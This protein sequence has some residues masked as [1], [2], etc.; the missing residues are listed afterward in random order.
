[1]AYQIVAID[2]DLTNKRKNE[3]YKHDDEDEAFDENGL[4]RDGHMYKV[5]LR[6][7]DSLSKAVAA[8]VH[9]QHAADATRDALRLAWQLR[10]HGKSG[11]ASG[12]H[13]KRSSC[14]SRI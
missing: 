8:H 14:G 9:D 2:L 11:L 6:F 5:P 12:N 13:F 3:M 7:C 10:E 4:L 1:V